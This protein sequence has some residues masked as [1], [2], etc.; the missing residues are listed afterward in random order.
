MISL[1]YR[2]EYGPAIPPQYRQKPKFLRLQVMTALFLLLFVLIVRQYFPAGVRTL[3]QLLLPIHPSVTQQALDEL[4]IDIR[5][6]ESFGNAFTAFCVQIISHD[7]ALS[8]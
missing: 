3:R 7:Q 6:G 2:I 1:S 8:G 4:V 5:D